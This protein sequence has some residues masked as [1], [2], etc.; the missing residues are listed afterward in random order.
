M[1]IS[2]IGTCRLCAHVYLLILLTTSL[3]AYSQA[4]ILITLIPVITSFI[5]LI[6]LSVIWAAFNLITKFSFEGQKEL[7]HLLSSGNFFTVTYCTGALLGACT[8]FTG[9]KYALTRE[10]HLIMEHFTWWLSLVHNIRKAVRRAGS[11]YKM[12]WTPVATQC[13]ARI[14]SE[15]IRASRRVSKSFCM[16][17]RLRVATRRTALRIL[18]TRL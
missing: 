7:L 8:Y 17:F 9:L 5:T 12:I 4:Y 14:D 11:P 15:S 18:W 16:D 1:T 6:R 10:L 13:N 2:A 3:N